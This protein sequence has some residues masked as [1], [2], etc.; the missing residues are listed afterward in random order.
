MCSALYRDAHARACMHRD[1]SNHKAST[2]LSYPFTDKEM[3]PNL[4]NFPKAIPPSS[5]RIYPISVDSKAHVLSIMPSLLHA[6][7]QSYKP[8][9]INLVFYWF[10]LWFHGRSVIFPLCVFVCCEVFCPLAEDPS[11]PGVPASVPTLCFLISAEADAA[12]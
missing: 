11:S 5:G 1:I 10:D 4:S 2:S 7:P 8:M 12:H 3:M 6:T 9:E